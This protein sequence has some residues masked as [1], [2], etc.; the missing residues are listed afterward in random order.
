VAERA[1]DPAQVAGLLADLS[2]EIIAP[3]L[4]GVA[5]W[6]ASV[7]PDLIMGLIPQNAPEL[8]AAASD[9]DLKSTARAAVVWTQRPDGNYWHR[10][11]PRS[12]CGK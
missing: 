2:T 3:S 6:I 11:P 10:S 4:I 5:A 9:G 12:E 1:A 8:A 7:E